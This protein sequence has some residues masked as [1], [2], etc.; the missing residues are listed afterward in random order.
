MC[1]CVGSPGVGD[2]ERG[3]GRSRHLREEKR[4]LPLGPVLTSRLRVRTLGSPTLGLNPLG[5]LIYNCSV[6]QFTPS[7]MRTYLIGEIGRIIKQVNS[8]KALRQVWFRVSAPQMPMVPTDL[9][10]DQHKRTHRQLPTDRL[11]QTQPSFLP[12]RVQRGTR[13]GEGRGFLGAEEQMGREEKRLEAVH[14]RCRG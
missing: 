11:R 4:G 3:V 13:M 14:R 2:R 7:S 12:A 5:Q 10:G 9:S 6:Y 1:V 8:P